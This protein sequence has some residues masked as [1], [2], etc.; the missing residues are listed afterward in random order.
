M[1]QQDRDDYHFQREGTFFG[2]MGRQDQQAIINIGRSSNPKPISRNR[3]YRR[4][5]KPMQGERFLQA[6]CERIDAKLDSW[7]SLLSW[8]QWVLAGVTFLVLLFI[9]DVLYF[10]GLAKANVVGILFLG[11]TTIS[12]PWVTA[13]LIRLTIMAILWTIGYIAVIGLYLLKLSAI[14][15]GIWLVGYLVY[16]VAN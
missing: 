5:S 8:K 4:P 12:L 2:E 16:L 3:V 7:I 14:L 10:G 11:V 13:H 9:S 6:T 1:N 15:G